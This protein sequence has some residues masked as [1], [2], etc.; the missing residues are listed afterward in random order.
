[1][2]DNERRAIVPG[3]HTSTLTQVL[4]YRFF[5]FSNNTRPKAQNSRLSNASSH[6]VA[7]V[8][9]IWNRRF[10]SLFAMAV[11]PEEAT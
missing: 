9:A 10:T 3:G 7:L 8:A 11:M 6:A 1:M 5:F 2:P 4:L